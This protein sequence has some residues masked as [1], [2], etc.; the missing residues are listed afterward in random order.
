LRLCSGI[1]SENL[2]SSSDSSIHFSSF[3][4]LRM[5]TTALT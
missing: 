1:S 4:S 3:T 5:H 2:C